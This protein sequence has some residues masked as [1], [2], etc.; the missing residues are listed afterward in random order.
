VL[1][2]S[3]FHQLEDK[4]GTAGAVLSGLAV[5]PDL[6]LFAGDQVYLDLPTLRD[7]D[8]DPAW[9]GNKFQNDYLANWFGDRS[10]PVGSWAIPRGYPEVLAL[11]PSAFLPDDHEYWNNYPFASSAIQ[12]SWTEGGRERWRV[13]AEAVYRGFQQSAA[14]PFGAA[15]RL[16]VAPLSILLLDTRS[17]RSLTERGGAGD[18]L[19]AAGRAALAAWVDRLVVAALTEQPWFGMLV[20]GQSLFSPAAGGFKGAVADYEFGDYP[21]DFAFMVEQ[22]ERVTAAGLPLILAT[23]D[24][25]WGRVLRADAPGAPGATIYEVI[26]SPTSLVSTVLVDQA[27][28]VWGAI[29]G[30]LGTSDRWPRHADPQAAPERFGSAGQYFPAVMPRAGGPAA[31]MRGNQAFMLRFVRA[32]SGL[33]VEVVCHPLSGDAAFDAAEQW[34]TTLQLRAP[35]V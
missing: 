1:L 17:R 2:V 7:F 8:D 4:T 22:L 5:R 20:T 29:T 3:C 18:L 9:L 26:S 32:G 31:A 16:D 25:H 21:A 24:V 34:S 6:T 10:A 13:A 12:N 27:K 35:R 19:G 15:R 11:A 23:G 33:D 14:W 28:E 30:L